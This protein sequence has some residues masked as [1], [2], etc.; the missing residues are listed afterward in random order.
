MRMNIRHLASKLRVLWN[1]VVKGIALL[2]ACLYDLHTDN[3]LTGLFFSGQEL[4]SFRQQSVPRL[5][6]SAH[7]IP[8][9][10]NQR[11]FP[12]CY[13]S[14]YGGHICSNDGLFYRA[15]SKWLC[16]AVALLSLALPSSW[17]RFRRSHWWTARCRQ[18]SCYGQQT[19]RNESNAIKSVMAASK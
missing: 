12:L 17:W 6:P 3:P 15:S 14:F 4:W 8:S 16:P 7:F 13:L 19:V 10:I 1:Q 11:L 9:S 2:R 5:C 18:L